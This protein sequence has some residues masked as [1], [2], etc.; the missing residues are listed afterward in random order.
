MTVDTDTHVLTPSPLT[1]DREGEE[2]QLVIMFHQEGGKN[3]AWQRKWK[4]AHSCAEKFVSKILYKASSFWLFCFLGSQFVIIM[5]ITYLLRQMIIK[6]YKSTTAQ[7]L[8]YLPQRLNTVWANSSVSYVPK[9]RRQTEVHTH[10]ELKH[11][12]EMRTNR[13]QTLWHSPVHTA[14]SI[15]HRVSFIIIYV[16]LYMIYIY[17]TY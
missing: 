12:W 11:I 3:R 7:C 8:I 1:G 6:F 5:Y 15:S 4:N 10:F 9:A 13:A 16:W 17:N 2:S 14:Q